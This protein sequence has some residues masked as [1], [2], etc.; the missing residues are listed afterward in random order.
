[1]SP[2]WKKTAGVVGGATLSLDDIENVKLRAPTVSGLPADER[3]A[4][5]WVLIAH[6]YASMVMRPKCWF[7]SF[8]ES[9]LLYFVALIWV[10][11]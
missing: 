4:A 6:S 9:F 7:V 10:C 11:I 2:V 1:M 5:C 8:L 3:N